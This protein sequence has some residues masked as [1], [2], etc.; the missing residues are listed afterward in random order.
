MT[1]ELGVY[2][3]TVLQYYT[4]KD[5]PGMYRLMNLQ[6]CTMTALLGVYRLTKLSN[7]STAWDVQAQEAPAMTEL[8]EMYGLPKLQ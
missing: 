6:Y 1:A 4:M 3:L 5:A 7:G 2:R 8:L